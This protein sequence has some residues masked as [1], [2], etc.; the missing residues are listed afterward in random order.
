MGFFFGI[1]SVLSIAALFS[2]PERA[3]GAV[4]AVRE[5]QALFVHTAHVPLANGHGIYAMLEK[6]ILQFM[7][8]LR[9]HGNVW[10]NP[11]L[12]NRLGTVM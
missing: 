10:G 5:V 9:V 7:L 6:E 3:K 1:A 12:H 11:S 2:L 4:L 8:D